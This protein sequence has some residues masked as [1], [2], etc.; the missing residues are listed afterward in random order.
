MLVDSFKSIL[1]IMDVSVLSLAGLD[2]FKSRGF[3][4]EPCGA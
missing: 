2:S 4:F 1:K 3:L